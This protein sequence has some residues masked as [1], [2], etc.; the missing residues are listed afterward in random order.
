MKRMTLFSL[1]IIAI[2]ILTGC[3]MFSGEASFNE[4][5]CKEFPNDEGCVLNGIPI[6]VSDD[7]NLVGD[8][9]TPSQV[10]LDFGNGSNDILTISDDG[11]VERP[12]DPVREG[13]V[14]GGWYTDSDLTIPFDFETVINDDLTLYAKFDMITV[15]SPSENIIVYKSS[16]EV[17]TNQFIRLL[18]R[19]VGQQDDFNVDYLSASTQN[20]LEMF[21]NTGNGISY[22]FYSELG[23]TGIAINGTNANESTMLYSD[24]PYTFRMEAI[25]RVLWGIGDSNGDPIWFIPEPYS[26]HLSEGLYY[27]IQTK[28]AAE[29]IRLYG[30]MI[31][32]YQ[33]HWT[34]EYTSYDWICGE[35]YNE[36]IP[37]FKIGVAPGIE[38]IA[39]ALINGYNDV[40]PNFVPEIHVLD[41]HEIYRRVQGDLS[42]GDTTTYLHFGFG[43]REFDLYD[44][45]PI[46][47]ATIQTVNIDAIVLTTNSDNPISNLTPTD[48]INIFNGS[49]KTWTDI[50]E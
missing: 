41:T 49:Y 42:N 21:E 3:G 22:G 1:T 37:T 26:N 39:R 5:Y 10:N 19:Y 9:E 48:L 15:F 28:E 29:I 18:Y 2:I 17:L 4:K 38:S 34:T 23:N 30:G 32:D 50:P 40:C 14:F 20:I 8:N 45:E 25:N 43:D 46:G 44:T 7:N 24:Y 13:Y 35:H 6:G 16:D 47:G 11:T 27:F 33:N 31:Y 12:I 36:E